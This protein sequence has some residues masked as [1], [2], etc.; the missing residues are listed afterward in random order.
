MLPILLEILLQNSPLQAFARAVTL[1]RT[2][3]PAPLTPSSFVSSPFSFQLRPHLYQS[4]FPHLQVLGQVTQVP[5]YLFVSAGT[6]VYI[7]F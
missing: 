4:H 1:P 7:F 3:R 5:V 6:T 2:L